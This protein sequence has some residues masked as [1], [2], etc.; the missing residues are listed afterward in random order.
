MFSVD[1]VASVSREAKEEGN[2][3]GLSA[4]WN[5]EATSFFAT[6]MLMILKLNLTLCFN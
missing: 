3:R 4:V 6:L 2:E 5:V 1:Y